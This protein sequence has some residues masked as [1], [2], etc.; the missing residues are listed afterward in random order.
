MFA[1][2]GGG[3]AGPG[4]A[5]ER[6]LR[7]RRTLVL[8]DNAEHLLPDLGDRLASLLGSAPF[9]SCSSPAASVSS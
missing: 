4:A 3:E 6:H 9:S 2:E 7:G 8:L 1:I 5:I